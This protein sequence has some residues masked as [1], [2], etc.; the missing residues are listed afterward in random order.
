MGGDSMTLTIITINRNNAAGLERTLKSVLSQ[1]ATNFEYIVVDGSAPQPPPALRDK[2]RGVRG[3]MEVLAGFINNSLSTE[4]NFTRC[5]WLSPEGGVG[6]GFFSEPDTGIY[7]AMNKGIRMATGEYVLFI[8]SGDELADKHVIENFQNTVKTES[9]ICSGNLL[10]IHDSKQLTLHAPSEISLSYCIHTGLTHPNTFIRKSLFDKYGLYNE[11]N[12]IVSDWEFFLVAAG[13]HTCMYQQ[14][15]FTVARFYED[16][17]S[18]QNKELVNSEMEQVINRLV[19]E[20]ILKD[21]K[22]LNYLENLLSNPSHK[23]IQQSVLM[24]KLLVMLYKVR[25]KLHRGR[26]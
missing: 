19:P 10:L 5:S 25:Q 8:N 7:N 16:G 13:L 9:E 6:G 22:R 21:I 11:A 4:N 14:L 1:T 24:R 3:D 18:S 23:L 20:P 12:K 17:I 15:D 26:P 2:W